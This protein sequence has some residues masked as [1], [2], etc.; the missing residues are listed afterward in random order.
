MAVAPSSILTGGKFFADFS[1]YPPCKA[2]MPT[3]TTLLCKQIPLLENLYGKISLA[4]M[5]S[6]R[7][8][9]MQF[10]LFCTADVHSF[11]M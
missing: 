5:L 6:N 7:F 1:S 8:N 11:K 4:R 10:F 2:L 3:L 9:S